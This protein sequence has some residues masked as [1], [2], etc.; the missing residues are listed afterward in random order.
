MADKNWLVALGER[1]SNP[2]VENLPSDDGVETVKK[3]IESIRKLQDTAE[4]IA[5]AKDLKKEKAVLEK[6][7]EKTKDEVA[8]ERQMRLEEELKT[9]R[10]EIMQGKSGDKEREKE[11]EHKYE[12]TRLELERERTNSL[13]SQILRLEQ[14][15][16]QE[17]SKGKEDIADQI[18]KIKEAAKELGIIG[19]PSAS[20]PALSAEVQ[21]KLAEMNKDL[22]IRLAEM[23]DERA[24]RDKEWKL[25]LI[26][27]ED[28]RE[29]KKAELNAKIQ[30]RERAMGTFEDMG[31]A[32]VDGLGGEE[33]KTGEKIEKKVEGDSGEIIPC[34]ECKKKVY[35]PQGVD[36]VIC[37][38]CQ[39]SLR[40]K[41]EE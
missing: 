10:G 3:G 28:E 15:M 27:W 2:I 6:E 37:P 40:V 11:L 4:D 34:P 32:L 33:T 1:D 17:G 38:S 41:E 8:A 20:P 35:V 12:E 18:K 13:Q 24:A 21:I 36:F 31:Q 16:K 19:V 23:A 7:L 39:S 14:T 9:I 5:G 25:T 26:K 30:T 29:L 22:Q